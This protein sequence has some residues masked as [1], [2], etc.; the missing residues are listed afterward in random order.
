MLTGDV[1]K[2]AVVGRACFSWSF[3]V[4][5]AY[6]MRRTLLPIKMWKW[7]AWNEELIKFLYRVGCNMQLL[8]APEDKASS[9][10]LCFIILFY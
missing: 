9:L 8:T 5:R 7:V 4:L 10:L 6:T 1:W 2:W 3:Q